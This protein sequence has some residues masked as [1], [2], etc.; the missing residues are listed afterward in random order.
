MSFCVTRTYCKTLVSEDVLRELPRVATMTTQNLDPVETTQLLTRQPSLR[1][2]ATMLA[3][4]RYWRREGPASCG[5]EREIASAND[6]IEPL[7][8]E[9]IDELCEWLDPK[10]TV[11]S[12]ENTPE[13]F[14]QAGIEIYELALT[15]LDRF[16]RRPDDD[17]ANTL[18]SAIDSYLEDSISLDPAVDALENDI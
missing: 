9:E 13:L 6:T 7:N 18:C 12:L 5:H 10:H 4:L 14:E 17:A 16:Q 3:A 8:A 2:W 1:Q 11:G 15:A